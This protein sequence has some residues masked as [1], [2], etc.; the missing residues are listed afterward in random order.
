MVA[1]LLP[2][3]ELTQPILSRMQE[4]VQRIGQSEGYTLILERNESADDVVASPA[5]LA[6]EQELVIE[7]AE[8][9]STVNTSSA[10]LSRIVST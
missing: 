10:T 4:I 9:R 3:L 7:I 6:E 8:S 1:F 5:D 2:V